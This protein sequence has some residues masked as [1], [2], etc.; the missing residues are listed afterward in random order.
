MRRSGT[1][2]WHGT[3]HELLDLWS[4][5]SVRL[6]PNPNLLTSVTSRTFIHLYT[7]NGDTHEIYL[8]VLSAL[9]PG[10]RNHLMR[11]NDSA[12]RVT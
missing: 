12:A 2:G 11:R 4:R 10:P 9:P 3:V 8:I 7:I 1:S 6:N 5:R